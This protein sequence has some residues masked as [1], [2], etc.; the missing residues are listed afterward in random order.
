MPA[1]PLPPQEEERLEALE[2]YDILDTPEEKALDDLVR[3]AASICDTPIALISLV[4]DRRQWFKSHIGLE[5]R[6]TPRDLAFC[7]Y[8]LFDDELL[9]VED[10]C[11]DPRFADNDFVT[12]E[13]R[14]RFYAGAPL[15]TSEGHILGTVCVLDHEPRTISEAQK[16]AL[17]TLARAVVDQFELRRSLAMVR[18]REKELARARDAALEASRLKTRFLANMSHELRTPLTSIL[19]FAGLLLR[20]PAEPLSTLQEQ[21]VGHIAEGG[22]RLLS[23][24]N[25]LLDL[26]KIEAGKAEVRLESVAVEHLAKEVLA[27]TTPLAEKKGL[28]LKRKFSPETP[29]VRAD[30]ER[31]RQVLLNL[32]SNAIKFTDEGEVTLRIGPGTQGNGTER[33]V[34]IT[35]HDTGV[36]IAP[37]S[38]EL[39]FAEFHQVAGHPGCLQG[40]GLGLALCRELVG[41][42][43]G[44]I[45][46]ESVPGEGST[47]VFTLPVAKDFSEKEA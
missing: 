23:M 38:Q 36:G 19:G 17:R 33:S 42:M 9:I 16:T 5:V 43:G 12:G 32:L 3:L 39:I 37:E 7:A 4:D 15:L 13:L 10:A 31:V 25:D 47:F 6:E 46:V 21:Y 44:E 34:E 29:K 35:V 24:I 22:Q 1:A 11:K 20:G 40:T 18:H 45:G 2:R 41:Q 14:L 28:V 27:T 30:P 26:S 8:A